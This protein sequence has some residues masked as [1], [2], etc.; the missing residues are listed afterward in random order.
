MLSEAEIELNKKKLIYSFHLIKYEFGIH[1][2][3][4]REPATE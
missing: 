1:V 4:H 2:K 3:I